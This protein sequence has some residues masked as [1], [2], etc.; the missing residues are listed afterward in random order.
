MECIMRNSLSVLTIAAGLSFAAC[1]D[2]TGPRVVDASA[3]TA[4]ATLSTS[5]LSASSPSDSAVLRVTVHNPHPYAVSTGTS[6][7]YSWWS[8]VIDSVDDP[9]Q[10]AWNLR[11]AERPLT[12]AA[13]ADTVQLFVIRVRDPAMRLSPGHFRVQG[14][15]DRT[16]SSPLQLQVIP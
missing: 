1:S 13:G 7:A 6:A 10:G 16:L 15:L 14:G 11:N 5:V 3:I 2:V 4:R 12:I 9:T 8:L